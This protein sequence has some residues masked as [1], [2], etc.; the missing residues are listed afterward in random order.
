MHSSDKSSPLLIFMDLIEF[1]ALL[2]M[3]AVPAVM[4]VLSFTLVKNILLL[5]MALTW[6]G[7]A[8]FIHHL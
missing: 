2:L 8:F 5:M 6:L 7:I 1:L 3:Y 4:I